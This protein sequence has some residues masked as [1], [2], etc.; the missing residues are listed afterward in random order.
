MILPLFYKQLLFITD[1]YNQQWLFPHD[2][3]RLMIRGTNAK[4]HLHSLKLKT[5]HALNSG[6]ISLSSQTRA[7]MENV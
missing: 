7:F 4:L 5:Q 6:K 2:Q 3:L 1:Q